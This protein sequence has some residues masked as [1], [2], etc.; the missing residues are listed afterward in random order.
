MRAVETIALRQLIQATIASSTSV[1]ANQGFRLYR[2][3][4][5]GEQVAG[6][7]YGLN[8]KMMIGASRR[9]SGARPDS[10][11]PGVHRDVVDGWIAGGNRYVHKI[12]EMGRG[13]PAIR[14]FR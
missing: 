9:R 1:F 12:L 7:A 13:R 5:H 3:R 11:V 4:D 14:V 2:V 10:G 6:G 8:G